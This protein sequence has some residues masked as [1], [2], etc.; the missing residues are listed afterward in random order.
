MAAITQGVTADWNATAAMILYSVNAAQPKKLGNTLE[1][2]HDKGADTSA[3]TVRSL[4]AVAEVVGTFG[5]EDIAP[6]SAAGVAAPTPPG[7]AIG[8]H[9]APYPRSPWARGGQAPPT[10]PYAIY[11]GTYVGNGTEQDLSFDAPIHFLWIRPLSGS[12]HGLQ[13]WSSLN[14]SHLDGGQSYESDAPVEVLIDPAFVPG[15]GG[16]AL[17]RTLVRITGA[18]AEK[19]ANTVVYSYVAISDPGLRFLDAGAFKVYGDAA[20]ADYVESLDLSTFNPDSVLALLEAAGTTTTQRLHFQGLG[21]AATFLTP[22]AGA[23]IAGLSKAAGTL[24]AKAALLALL[25]A[26]TQIGY[27][28]LRRDDGS[29]DAGVPAAMQMATYVGDGNASRTISFAPISGKRPVFAMVVGHTGTTVYRDHQ[30]TGTT[31]T[32]FPSTANAATGITGGG[33]DSLSV[34]VLCNAAGV[35]YDVWV[36]PGDSAAGNGGFSPPGSFTPVDPSAGPGGPGTPYDNTPSDPEN[37]IPVTTPPPTEPGGDGTDFG[38]QCVDASTKIVNQALSHIG[39]SKYVGD[40][41]TEQSEEAAAARLHFSDDLTATLRDFPWPFATRYAPLVRVAGT[42][43]AP[44]NGDWTYSF[45]APADMVMARRIVNPSG[46]KRAY[47]PLPP[48]FRAGSDATGELIYTNQQAVIDGATAEPELEYTAR[49][50]CAASSGDALFRQTLAYRH[51]ASLALAL[52]RDTT[53]ATFCMNVYQGL[54]VK[55]SLVGAQEQQ[56]EPEGDADWISG[57]L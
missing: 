22:L 14:A 34:G 15:L 53:K 50:T 27:L 11:A 55:A 36:L 31:S 42:V 44:V 32:Q 10:R 21:S 28:A 37:P 7:L 4:F 39:I 18:G 8:I 26:G 49:P 12:T 20:T 23:E 9:N 52:A 5:A 48:T 24:T 54:L 43:A 1:L 25:P 29:G 30:H 57:R 13:W 56:Q 45:R 40:I 41:T 16:T 6:A 19:N 51:A 17:L 38:D 46:V 47:D 2:V 35:T 3:S 33:I